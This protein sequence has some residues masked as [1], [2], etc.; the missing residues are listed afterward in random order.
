M[1]DTTDSR[2][3]HESPVAVIHRNAVAIAATLTV[4]L[5]ALGAGVLVGRFVGGAFWVSWTTMMVFVIVDS[6]VVQFVGEGY[7]RRGGVIELSVAV[8]RVVGGR[9]A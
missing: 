8:K 7:Y 2:T 9:N 4:A 3:R 1:T 6:V 5:S